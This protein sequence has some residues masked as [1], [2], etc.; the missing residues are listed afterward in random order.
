M[1]GAGRLLAYAGLLAVTLGCFVQNDAEHPTTGGPPATFT[2]RNQSSYEICY[3]EMWPT[4]E[5][6]GSGDW[7]G[8]SETIPPAASRTFHVTTGTW[9]VRMQDCAHTLLFDRDGIAIADDVQLDF[10]TPE[11]STP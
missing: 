6:D 10:Q 11:R 5:G 3:V 4:G 7:L 9:H 2:V 8:P 1:R